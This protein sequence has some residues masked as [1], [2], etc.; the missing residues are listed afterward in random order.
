MVHALGPR[1][2]DLDTVPS[3]KITNVNCPED[4]YR[5]ALHMYSDISRAGV[6]TY[7]LF[8]LILLVNLSGDGTVS[9]TC[10]MQA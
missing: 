1:S 4:H 3:L 6:Y 9:S 2:A 10:Q 8:T 5:E 7:T